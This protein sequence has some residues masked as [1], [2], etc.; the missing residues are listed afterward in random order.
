MPALFPLKI[1]DLLFS[2]SNSIHLYAKSSSFQTN[3]QLSSLELKNNR[4][5]LS[6]D[7]K[8]EGWETWWRSSVMLIVQRKISEP[9]SQIIHL[10]YLIRAKKYICLS[11]ITPSLSLTLRL[12]WSIIHK[13]V[14]LLLPTTLHVLDT[15]EKS[16]KYLLMTQFF[17]PNI[18]SML[19]LE[20]ST[21]S[22][23][24]C[25][26]FTTWQFPEDKQGVVTYAIAK[27]LN[28]TIL[29]FIHQS[30]K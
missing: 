7:R 21:I 23:F 3:Y 15:V 8:I 6:I 22:H 2:T 17:H 19:I 11:N 5:L 18:F 10:E 1:K 28:I 13:Y 27:A 16:N 4:R 26:C 29:S 9:S 12:I 30:F 24:I 14:E 25:I 20:Q